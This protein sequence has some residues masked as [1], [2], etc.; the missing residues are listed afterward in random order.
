[1]SELWRSPSGPILFLWNCVQMQIFPVHP[2]HL[3][4][5]ASDCGLCPHRYH[6]THINQVSGTD[7]DTTHSNYFNTDK[8]PEYALLS[9]FYRWE[10]WDWEALNSL[11][12]VVL[13]RTRLRGI[14]LSPSLW[15][16]YMALPCHATLGTRFHSPQFH[17][18]QKTGNIRFFEGLE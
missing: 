9:P 10:H 1:M 12:K 14:D 15:S 16:Y 18:L 13:A 2:Y 8:P 3:T 6:L 17:D 5:L 4:T 7:L 11:C